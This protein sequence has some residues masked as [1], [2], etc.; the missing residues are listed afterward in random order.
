MASFDVESFFNNIPLQETIDLCVQNLF[1]DKN[2]TEGL[3][4]NSFC[5][6]LTVTMTKVF[7]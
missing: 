2:C 6:L 5:E 3:P 4:E 7:I 1:K